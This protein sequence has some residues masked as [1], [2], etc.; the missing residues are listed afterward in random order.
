MS[1]VRCQYIAQARHQGVSKEFEHEI[2]IQTIATLNVVCASKS[3]SKA[4]P[5]ETPVRKD[6]PLL[7]QLKTI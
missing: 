7:Q 3:A 2:Y 1:D 6:P 4:I 5:P